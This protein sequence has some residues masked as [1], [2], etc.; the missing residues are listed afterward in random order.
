MH[1]T[2]PLSPP[3]CFSPQAELKEVRRRQLE[4]ERETRKFLRRESETGSGGFSH[5]SL[6][7]GSLDDLQNRARS[8][9]NSSRDGGGVLPVSPS[10]SPHPLSPSPPPPVSSSPTPLDE[11][12]EEERARRQEEG[13]SSFFPSFLIFALVFVLCLSEPSSL[14]LLALPSPSRSRH[15]SLYLLSLSLSL[16]SCVTVYIFLAS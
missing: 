1:C 7:P 14:S 9:S 3:C 8:F 11:I 12:T 5:Y 16:P 4:N 10:G 13:A 2:Y 15:L 6:S